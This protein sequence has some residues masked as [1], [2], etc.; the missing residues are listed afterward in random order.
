M[1]HSA[2]R[3]QRQAE[4]LSFC[5]D[6]DWL[7]RLETR[8]RHPLDTNGVRTEGAFSCPT[9]IIAITTP[10]RSK[11]GRRSA[12]DGRCGSRR[13]SSILM[14]NKSQAL[15][16]ILDNVKTERA[17][18]EVDDRRALAE[19]ADAVAGEVFNTATAAK[20]GERRVQRRGQAA[21]DTRPRS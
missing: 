20:A 8:Y 21:R 9:T 6:P 16:R 15:V 11:A 2:R 13:T 5:P 1:C 14:I 7:E 4:H 18:A 19:Y 10:I 12:S 17:Q 3:E